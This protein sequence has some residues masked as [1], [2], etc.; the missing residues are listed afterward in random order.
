[1]L[2]VKDKVGID[3]DKGYPYFKNAI[4]RFQI[5]QNSNTTSGYYKYRQ[6]CNTR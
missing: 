4:A 2:A 1:M 3:V 5:A 6:Q